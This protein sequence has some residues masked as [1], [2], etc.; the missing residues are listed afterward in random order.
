MLRWALIFFAISVVAGVFQFTQFTGGPVRSAEISLLLS[1]AFLI[2]FIAS[3]VFGL[4]ALGNPEAH[5]NKHPIANG[6]K[7]V[8]GWR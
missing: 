6:I 5:E 7:I 4:L 2:P 8:F 1:F 3:L